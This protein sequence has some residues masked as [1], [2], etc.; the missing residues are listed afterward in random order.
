[1]P[2][3]LPAPLHRFALKLAHRLRL[4][5]WAWRKPEFHGCNAILFNGAGEVLL[6]RHSYQAPGRWM[7]PGGGLRR[8]EPAED[9][10]RREALE[11]TGCRMRDCVDCGIDLVSVRGAR[12]NVHLVAGR[13]DDTPV[14]DGREIVAAR[15][16]A[17]DALP[18]AITSTGRARIVRALGV[19]AQNSAS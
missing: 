7:L 14:A 4:A 9:A 19:L 6:V 13:T 5:W 2:F 17:F 12:N 16:F 8:G 3:R 18:A 15:F 1:M 10:A 11:E